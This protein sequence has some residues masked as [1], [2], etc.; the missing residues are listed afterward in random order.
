MGMIS[1]PYKEYIRKAK[2]QVNDYIHDKVIGSLIFGSSIEKKKDKPNDIDIALFYLG[3][4]LVFN[5]IKNNE[6]TYDIIYYPLTYLSLLDD[7]K[8]RNSPDTWY[9][10]SLYINLLKNSYLLY[11]PRKIISVYKN[12]A[13]NWRWTL[14][15]IQS[16]Y[17]NTIE[18]L[19]IAKGMLERDRFFESLLS[20]RDASYNY[21]IYKLMERQFIPSPRPKDLYKK[22][23]EN[24]P[25]FLELFEEING[26]DNI[27][28]HELQYVIE[29]YQ[30]IWKKNIPKKRGAYSEYINSLRILSKKDFKTALLNMRYSAYLLLIELFVDNRQDII[31][32][33]DTPKHLFLY[34]KSRS[35][36]KLYILYHE[37]H[38]LNQDL[39][40]K[41]I[42]KYIE[43]LKKI[44]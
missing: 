27:D 38:T 1:Y 32:P 7:K 3:K 9:R 43:K 37:L 34:Q 31:T 10:V 42:K 15:E 33:Y 30:S 18:S 12:K 14:Q 5:Q 23:K 25:L 40:K 6:E 13:L 2:T 35:F 4:E 39:E 22:L 29:H 28:L 36:K 8:I 41:E 21:T 19:R 11:D 26:V 17:M 24:I 44:I 16:V 20:I